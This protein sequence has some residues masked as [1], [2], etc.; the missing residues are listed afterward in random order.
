MAEPAEVWVTRAQPQAE[1][2]AGRL[3][4]RGL[5]PLVA[6]LLAVRPLPAVLDLQGVGALA[7]TSLNAVDAFVAVSPERGLPVFAVGDATAEAAR[8]AGF[9]HVESAAGDVNALAALVA[10]RGGRSGEVLHPSALQPAGDLVALL[11]QAGVPARRV[12]LYETVPVPPSPAAAEA[13]PGLRA[14]LLHSPK[15]AAA[16]AAATSGWPAGEARVLCLSA[17]VAQALGG[18]DGPEPEVAPRPDEAAL[19]NLLDVT[20]P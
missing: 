20:P 18:G 12:A 14:V 11:Q 9:G 15:G 8:R 1:A 13:W 2:T 17:A 19:L 3:R 7:F 4:E 6:P 16:F 10:A 5:R